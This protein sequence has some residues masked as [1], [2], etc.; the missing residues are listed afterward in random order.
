[1]RRPLLLVSL[2]GAFL[3]MPLLSDLLGQQQSKSAPLAHAALALSGQAHAIVPGHA[4]ADLQ[5][6]ALRMDG[7]AGCQ[8]D[9]CT[10][11]R[12]AA[13]NNSPR[14]IDGLLWDINVHH[15]SGNDPRV[16]V[17]RR[18]RFAMVGRILTAFRPGDNGYKEDGTGVTLS[19]GTLVSP[20]LVLTVQHAAFNGG[21]TD[22]NPRRSVFAVGEGGS[23]FK[24]RR[25]DMTLV[26][27]LNYGGAGQ[28][29]NDD[30]A[31]YRLHECVGLDPEIGW[32]RTGTTT[33]PRH[34]PY[35]IA[36]MARDRDI[37]RLTATLE[38]TIRG[39]SRVAGGA[40]RLDRA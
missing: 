24:Y 12:S 9:E 33:P 15:P 10:S 27:A 35:F 34:K 22:D 23:G 11:M 5:D 40:G 20:C 30:V 37:N 28:S 39:E 38:C 1:M 16:Y 19:T 26:R 17:E 21:P 25:I 29:P 31:L 2:A 7:S 3:S 18:G 4:A 36:G 13:L 8:P 6:P 32:A 14:L